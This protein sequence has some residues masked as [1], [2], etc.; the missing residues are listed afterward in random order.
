MKKTLATLLNDL[1]QQNIKKPSQQF[2]HS[3][4]DAIKNLINP[5]YEKFKNTPLDIEVDRT[6]AFQNELE[7]RPRL[8][9]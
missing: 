2:I 1:H 8:S 7:N 6:I 4:F 3:I 5:M 9:Y